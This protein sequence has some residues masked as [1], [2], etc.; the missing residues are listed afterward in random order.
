MKVEIEGQKLDVIIKRTMTKR[1][2]MTIKED[3]NIYITTNHL[4]RNKDILN[5]IEDHKKFIIKSLSLRNKQKEYQDSFYYLGKKYDIVYLNTKEII[6]A[7][8]KIFINHNIDID[9]WLKK[10]ANRIFKEELDKIY[11]IFPITIPYPNL[12]IRN[13]KTRWGVCNVKTN[14]VTLNFS[15]IKRNIKYLDYVIVHELSHLVHANHSKDFWKLVS[16]LVPDYKNLRKEL[17][18]YE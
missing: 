8:T 13:M 14:R 10:E 15:L 17:N 5:F 11:S 18:N 12:T 4:V 6:I 2:N 9:K 16:I 7:D 1:I 3:R